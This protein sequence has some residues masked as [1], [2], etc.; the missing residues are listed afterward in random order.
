VNSHA[1]IG[2]SQK[3][4]QSW[5]EDTRDGV[6]RRRRGCRVVGEHRT[7][8]LRR[9]RR[10]GKDKGRERKKDR[11]RVLKSLRRSG[12]GGER[13]EEEEDRM[14]GIR[15]CEDGNVEGRGRSSS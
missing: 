12:R 4:R 1:S 3:G 13:R 10:H 7:A 8:Q 6:R 11:R 15:R 14:A 5:R 2:G 9:V